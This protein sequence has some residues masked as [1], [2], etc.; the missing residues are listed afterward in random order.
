MYSAGARNDP[1]TA[2]D[3]QMNGSS[4]KLAG[5]ATYLSAHTSSRAD[6]TRIVAPCTDASPST[7][8]PDLSPRRARERLMYHHARVAAERT[9]KQVSRQDRTARAAPACAAASIAARRSRGR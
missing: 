9:A 7:T 5:A 8:Q 6:R 1:A 3:S 2:L 4:G